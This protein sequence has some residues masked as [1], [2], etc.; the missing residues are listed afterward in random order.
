MKGFV[1]K[2]LVWL[3]WNYGA[4]S[5]NHKSEPQYQWKCLF[6]KQK[7]PLFVKFPRA[8][9][10][11]TLP[12]S[13][14]KAQI[15]QS[16]IGFWFCKF[17]WKNDVGLVVVVGLIVGFWLLVSF[18]VNLV[19]TSKKSGDF[20]MA[21]GFSRPFSVA[22][23]LIQDH[24]GHAHKSPAKFRMWNGVNFSEVN[25][26]VWIDEQRS[27]P[28]HSILLIGSWQDPKFRVYEIIYL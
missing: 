15:F 10:T 26:Q 22:V 21:S 28:L 12:A 24:R 6:L 9:P 1:Q 23:C 25:E 18:L 19:E 17:F 20:L 7:P 2:D 4:K 11:T 5:T 16:S 13:M 14:K 3:R 27:K 8:F